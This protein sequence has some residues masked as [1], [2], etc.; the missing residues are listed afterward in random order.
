MAEKIKVTPEELIS[1]AAELDGSAQA[2]KNIT[3][4]MINLISGIN[5]NVWG[6]EAS[7]SFIRK[8]QDMQSGINK[9][10]KRTEDQAKHLKT[11][12]EEYKKTEQANMAAAKALKN[13]FTS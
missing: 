8:F 10:C 7:S 12:G 9:M 2:I 13:Q 6:G 5:S 1:A 3:D 11:I 4:Q